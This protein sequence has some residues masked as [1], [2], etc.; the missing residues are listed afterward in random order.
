MV[1]EGDEG[2]GNRVVSVT[3]WDVDSLTYRSRGPV[4]VCAFRSQSS[5]DYPGSV[6]WQHFVAPQ[7]R[8]V[9]YALPILP[10]GRPY[11]RIGS[12]N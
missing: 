4:W 12:R 2:C 10:P 3:V 6:R 7:N 11:P 1:D 5:Y 9:F 8:L